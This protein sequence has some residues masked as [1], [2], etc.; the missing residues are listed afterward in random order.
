MPKSECKESK[1]KLQAHATGLGA[2][3]AT[4]M[5]SV[6]D[7]DDHIASTPAT[8]LS[9]LAN[10]PSTTPATGS[11][12]TF[13]AA[14]ESK[15]I[16]AAPSKMRPEGTSSKAASTSVPVAVSVAPSQLLRRS[17]KFHSK[18]T[19]AESA[20]MKRP[21]SLFS[22]S[23]EIDLSVYAPLSSSPQRRTKRLRPNDSE[24]MCKSASFCAPIPKS[25]VDNSI[26]LLDRLEAMEARA[27]G[28][29]KDT[30]LC[31]TRLTRGLTALRG[32]VEVVSISDESDEVDSGNEV[33]CNVSDHEDVAVTT[34]EPAHTVM[35]PVVSNGFD[36][37]VGTSRLFP[38][39]LNDSDNNQTDNDDTGN[40]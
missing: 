10:A 20:T 31:G 32:P 39:D 35:A 33:A 11:M 12:S 9:P 22:S 18:L 37:D 4:S 16:N 7:A 21:W 17:T 23:R 36:G 25:G 6:T 8:N 29:G 38:I 5:H 13:C 28:T 27:G 40:D 1:T 34:D 24:K 2:K 15:V 26:S 19:P 30:S 14:V 3:P